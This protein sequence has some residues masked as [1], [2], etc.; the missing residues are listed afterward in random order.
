M[1]KEESFWHGKNVKKYMNL[2]ITATDNINVHILVRKTE[3]WSEP[4]EVWF[5]DHMVK[6]KAVNKTSKDRQAQWYTHTVI[7]CFE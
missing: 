5:E 7:I 6:C 3:I 2:I 1:S 4:K